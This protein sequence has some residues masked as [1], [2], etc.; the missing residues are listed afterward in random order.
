M[1]LN[2]SH[3][4]TDIPI[5]KL[6]KNI[7]LTGKSSSRIENIGQTKKRKKSK[8]KVDIIG[9]TVYSGDN[10]LSSKIPGGL[11]SNMRSS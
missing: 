10:L 5:L 6:S 8:S 4:T 2:R 11:V 7:A 3:T 1:T 9:K